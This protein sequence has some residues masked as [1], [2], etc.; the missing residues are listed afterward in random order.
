M[1]VYLLLHPPS[2][3]PPAFAAPTVLRHHPHLR[4]PR[5]P[6]PHLPLLQSHTP[7]CMCRRTC[8]AW[9]AC[10]CGGTHVHTQKGA[11]RERLRVSRKCL[12]RGSSWTGPRVNPFLYLSRQYP[13]GHMYHAALWHLQRLS[14]REGSRSQALSH[15]Y[16]E[17]QLSA[18]LL[19]SF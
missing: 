18:V 1:R 5:C 16:H 8:M 17:I 15:C 4:R 19:Y 2:P 9:H 6:P 3:C 7:S 11:D 12:L 10:A 14:S 13:Q